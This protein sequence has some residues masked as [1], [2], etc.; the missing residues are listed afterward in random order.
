MKTVFVQDP[1]V[2]QGRVVLA[3]VS[4]TQTRI[5][6]ALNALG[7]E[8]LDI[9]PEGVLPAPVACH[10]DMRIHPLGAGDVVVG[11]G[12][13][14]LG[15]ALT[16]RG[17]HVQYTSQPLGDCYPQDIALNCFSLRECLFGLLKGTDPAI[18]ERYTSAGKKLV[19]VKQGYAK[20]SV[21]IVS[22]NAAITADAGLAA[23]LK[24]EGVHCLLVEQG[25]VVLPGYPCGFIGGACFL[26]APGILCFMGDVFTHPSAKEILAFC[27]RQEVSVRCL[28]DGPLYD[29]GS[30]LPLNVQEQP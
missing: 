13:A 9:P 29:I 11:K 26:M 2:P 27:E 14:F 6:T 12:D 16:K 30:V 19:N 18:L 24:R 17:M 25:G 5:L 3:A 4:C 21:G 8:T 1:H 7:I 28:V 23:C 10:A 22:E 20:C 15:D